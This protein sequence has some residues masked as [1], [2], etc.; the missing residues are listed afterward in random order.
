VFG[1]LDRV[2]R[3]VL[4]I[5]VRA[6]PVADEEDD[7]MPNWL[8]HND[9]VRRESSDW[10]GIETVFAAISA[11]LSITPLPD[12]PGEPAGLDVPEKKVTVSRQSVPGKGEILEVI[13]R[14][15][16]HVGTGKSY[17]VVVYAPPRHG[18]DPLPVVDLAIAPPTSNG[19]KA[20]RGEAA[21]RY[22][23]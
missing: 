8:Y 22:F 16:K 19:F 17:D 13:I 1:E 4:G 18:K 5:R 14:S 3:V 11:A 10:H 7:G 6:P 2:E 23:S 21:S 20:L 12:Q 9:L 15:L